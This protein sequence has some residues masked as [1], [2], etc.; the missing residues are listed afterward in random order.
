MTHYIDY[1]DPETLILSQDSPLD[2][3]FD[4][5]IDFFRN[6]HL[7]A[8]VVHKSYGTGIIAEITSDTASS[9]FETTSPPIEIISETN[10]PSD[11]SPLLITPLGAFPEVS[12]SSLPQETKRREI[13]QIATNKAAS[14]TV[15]LIPY[16]ITVY[17]TVAK[18]L[19][20]YKYTKK[21]FCF[22]TINKTMF[23][24]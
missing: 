2:E 8:L 23:F 4:L 18:A 15:L 24:Y 5:D 16:L 17:I 12:P 20:L 14:F 6:Y 13:I 11:L 21:S 7:G 19:A 10:P 3:P 9:T 1:N 22:N